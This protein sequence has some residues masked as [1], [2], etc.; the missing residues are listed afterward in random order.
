MDTYG[1]LVLNLRCIRCSICE[2]NEKKYF[3]I[4]SPFYIEFM[5]FFRNELLFL[6]IECEILSVRALKRYIFTITAFSTTNYICYFSL[7][8]KE[9]I[10]HVRNGVLGMIMHRKHDLYENCM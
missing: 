4:L 5:V 6:C 9:I 3:T 2:M 7:R 10:M 8:V 1:R